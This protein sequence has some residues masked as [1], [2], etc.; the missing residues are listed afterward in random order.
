M[1]FGDAQQAERHLGLRSYQNV[2]P[3]ASGMS[4]KIVAEPDVELIAFDGT[5][6]G[7]TAEG[8]DTRLKADDRISESSPSVARLLFERWT[9]TGSMRSR[10]ALI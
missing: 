5:F 7:F 8:I 3:A 6:D 4:Q 2:A 10:P 9:R 1:I